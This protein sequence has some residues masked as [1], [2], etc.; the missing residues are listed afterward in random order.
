MPFIGNYDCR[1]LFFLSRLDQLFVHPNNTLCVGS[2]F[3]CQLGIALITHT[4]TLSLCYYRLLMIYFVVEFITRFDTDTHNHTTH[5]HTAN[6]ALVG[7]NNNSNNNQLS[8]GVCVFNAAD[9]LKS[10]DQHDVHNWIENLKSFV[11]FRTFTCSRPEAIVLLFYRYLIRCLPLS[12]CVTVKHTEL[13]LSPQI[14]MSKVTKNEKRNKWNEILKE[15]LIKCGARHI[16]NNNDRR[17]RQQY[18]K[19]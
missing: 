7:D 5:A 2:A 9:K 16:N 3:S 4:R 12:V 8:D 15:R 17:Q 19:I 1:I 13:W 11:I 18:F 6:S 14:T 10:A